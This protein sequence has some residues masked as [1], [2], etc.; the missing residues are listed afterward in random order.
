[1]KISKGTTVK[2]LSLF[3]NLCTE[4]IPGQGGGEWGD[5]PTLKIFFW[6]TPMSNERGWGDD[7]WELFDPWVKKNLTPGSKNFAAAQRAATKFFSK[8]PWGGEAGEKFLGYPPT[9]P[10]L[11]LPKIG[12]K[13]QIFLK[14][15][16]WVSMVVRCFSENFPRSNPW[17]SRR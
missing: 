12:Q 11:I 4:S 16:P 17:V 5:D 9:I 2:R 14:K 6:S 7:P 8:V 3:T 1:M 15:T 13:L 10:P